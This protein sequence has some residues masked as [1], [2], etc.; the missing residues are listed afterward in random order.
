M[1]KSLYDVLSRIGYHHPLHPPATHIPV[2]M[3]IGAVVFI[4]AAWIFN[5]ESFARTARHCIV[6]AL[7]TAPVA[8]LLGLMD[9][10]HFYGGAWLF[11]IRVKMALAGLLITLLLTAWRTSQKENRALYRQRAVYAL[12]LVTV[13]ALGFFGGE[14]VYR[15]KKPVTAQGSAPA[16][17]GA[18]LFAGSCSMCH[19]TDSTETRIGPGLKNLFRRARLPVSKKPVNDQSIADQLKT[20]FDQMPAFTDLTNEQ[21]ESLVAYLKTI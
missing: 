18:G 10:Q 19:Y 7:L 20:P 15:S 14:I 17:Q 9:W 8:I 13:T 12:C 3:V 11:P 21:V 6:L 16:R 1:L 2:G 4:I 5:R